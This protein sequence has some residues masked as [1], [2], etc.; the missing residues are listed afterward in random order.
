MNTKLT[1]DTKAIVLLCAN[2]D[3]K[4]N[5]QFAP[6][7][8]SEY[9][10]IVSW[11][12]SMKK[13]PSDLFNK[14]LTLECEQATEI[15]HERLDYLLG[16]GM[17]LS[18]VLEE[19]EKIGIYLISRSDKEYP[20]LLKRHLKNSCPPFL[21]C[22]GNKELLNL[23]GLAIV[24]SRNVTEVAANF[25]HD[26]AQQCANKNIPIISGGAKGVDEISMLSALQNGGKVVGVL[27]DSLLE[28]TMSAKY[29]QYIASKQLILI[30]PYNPK[31]KFTV[32]T[33]MGR[34]KIIYSMSNCALVVSS[35]YNKGGTWA[36]A[37]EELKR[38]NAINV[39]VREDHELKG[40][41]E[42]IKKGAEYW[43]FDLIS[44]FNKF[45]NNTY[46]KDIS[47]NHSENIIETNNENITEN[48]DNH[49][50]QL[51]LFS[52]MDVN[53]DDINNKEITA[54][55]SVITEEKS[56]KNLESN[57]EIL[58]TFLEKAL[59]KYSTDD[60]TKALYH[61]ELSLILKNT[62]KPQ[63]LNT[64]IEKTGIGKTHLKEILEKACNEEKIE[65]LE[66]PIK[67]KRLISEADYL[68][69]I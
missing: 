29:R 12:I 1:E 6:L 49:E 30:T 15:S 22:C 17:L 60:F 64:L 26:V 3:I 35:D 50:R 19:Y 37:T 10:K 39:F 8:T 33:A 44:S 51:D 42:L 20:I 2:L 62:E 25:T 4:E 46:S 34:N 31:A 63:N 40:N 38:P 27:A 41:C 21:F 66:R 14:T 61:I 36:G 48:K 43:S 67:Y 7:K 28:K 65:K 9:A 59:T 68:A 24:G 45:I 47:H 13:R 18:V 54:E 69:Q 57:K 53:K 16:R 23:G 56:P 58:H 55:I 32:G 5:T 11:L 52:D